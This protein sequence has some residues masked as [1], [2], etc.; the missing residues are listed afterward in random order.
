MEPLVII[1]GIESENT[2][3]ESK[4]RQGCWPTSMK[5]MPFL[6]CK[7]FGKMGELFFFPYALSSFD[8]LIK[9]LLGQERL[10]LQF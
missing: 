4:F 5:K 7:L 3:S 1:Q 9:A 8:I 10:I 2:G 6:Y